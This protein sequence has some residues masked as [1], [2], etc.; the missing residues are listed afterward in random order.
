MTQPFTPR[1]AFCYAEARAMAERERAQTLRRLAGDLRAWLR[2]RWA[3][4]PWCAHGC[5]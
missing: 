3:S 5:R 1:P 2:A 4:R